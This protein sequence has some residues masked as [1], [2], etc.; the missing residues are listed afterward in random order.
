MSEDK[1]VEAP[2]PAP[3]P[4]PPPPKN[5]GMVTMTID[6]REVV[7][8]PGTNL[9][10]AAK[11]V[12]SEI[13]Y[14]CYHPRLTI[15][16]NCRMCLVEASNAPKLVPACQHSIGEGLVVK[17]TTDKVKAQQKSV[18]EF[19]LL[20]HP[21]DC[22][23]CDQAGEC[24]L[25]D[26]YMRYDFK[27]SRLDGPKILRN[28]RKVLGDL[29][30]L[31]QERCVLCTRCVRFMDEVAQEPQ[32]GVFGRGS[33]EVVDVAPH[34]GKLD[35]NYSGNIVDLCPVGALL[36][37]DFR[38]RA[39]AWFLSAA[40]SVCTGCSRGCNINVDFM[41]QDTY[42]FRPRENEAVNKSWMCDQG[43]LSYKQ[44]NQKRVQQPLV[45]KGA[46]AKEAHFVDVVKLLGAKL[47]GAQV[48][49]AVSPTFSNEDLMA[50]LAF[51]RDGLSVKSVYVTG[52]PQGQADKLLVTAD[53]NPNRKGLEWIARGFGVELKPFSELTAALDKGSI[54]NLLALGADVPEDQAEFVKRLSDVEHFA[55]ISMTENTVTAAANL[56]IGASAH[57]EDEGTFTQEAGITQRVRRAYPP[58]GDSHPLWKCA[59][60][61]A[62][63]L[64]LELKAGSSRE[65][66]KLLAASVPE[67]KD[68]AWDKNAPMNQ[69]R[70][71]IS[72]MA[73][74]ADGRPP[75]WRE[76]GAPNLRGL[77]LPPP[78]GT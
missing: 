42:R 29:V 16:A 32:L 11:T 28:K 19:L 26:Y 25:Q 70:P 10:E 27:P 24:K 67:L 56:V 58:K 41:G 65:V 43:R 7:V 21:V 55:V 52:R 13:P 54:K 17:T 5:P 74:G 37:R 66:F 63:E 3:P 62:K 31:D 50:A 33:H 73:S 12:G 49:V 22:S 57:V 60:E 1:K 2:K 72:T 20:N 59:V 14:Y 8:K 34:Y 53:K 78:S 47:K 68:Y 48:T 6:G 35:S 46:E 69:T 40:P 15:A 30:V 4:G 36:N 61:L 75:G 38:F 77:T 23:I 9:I 45:G 44:L 39:R 76:Q 18:M 64:G 71:G 51:V